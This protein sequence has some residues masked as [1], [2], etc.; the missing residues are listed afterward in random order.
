LNAPHPLS[1]FNPRLNIPCPVC[2]N[3]ATEPSLTG[4][5]VLFES[6]PKTFTLNACLSCRCLFL[7]P[8][9]GSEEIAGFYPTQYWWNSAKPGALKQLESIYRKL[10][11]SGHVAFVTQ[12]AG[13]RKGPDL[14]DVGCGSGTLLGLL[15][16]RGFRPMGV[17]FSSE[18]AQV[19]E[20]ENGVRV[21]VGSLAQAAFPDRSFDIVTLFHVME[22][23]SNPREVL[24]EVSRILKP[25]GVV[26]L[27]VPNIDSWQFK[28]FGAKWYGLDIPRHVIDYSK[29]S[30]LSLLKDSSF[31]PQRIKHFNLRDNAP[32]L[33]SSM[34]PSLDPVSRSVRQRKHGVREGALVAWMRHAAYLL[35]VLCAYPFAI[36]ESASG[37]GATLMIEARKK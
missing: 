26:V 24:S 1:P 28:A 32:A 33:A 8:M 27:Q 15:K 17:D 19:A 4:A 36:A 5:D 30:M 25:D 13:N 20:S 22:H 16:Q 10:A 3:P 18:A 29:A 6:T 34:F 21:V 12:A 7:N 23:V 14:L 31:E 11:L 2:L 35:L 9:P 37:H